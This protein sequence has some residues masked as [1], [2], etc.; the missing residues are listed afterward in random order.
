MNKDIIVFKADEGNATFILTYIEKMNLLDRD[1][2]IK[3]KTQHQK[4]EHIQEK[5]SR[6]NQYTVGNSTT[7]IALRVTTISPYMR[8][9]NTQK[10]LSAKTDR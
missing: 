8:D 2:Y 5:P 4:L 10:W 6:S 7:C 9:E 1:Q 3:L